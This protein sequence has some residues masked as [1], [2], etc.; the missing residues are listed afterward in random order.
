MPIITAIRPVAGKGRARRTCP[1]NRKTCLDGHIGL[2]ADPSA[3]AV[4]LKKGV[5]Y[6]SGR[7]GLGAQVS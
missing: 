5:L 3:G 2:D 4:I 6:P 7:P 1:L